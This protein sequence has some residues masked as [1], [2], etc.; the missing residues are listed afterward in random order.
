MDKLDFLLLKFGEHLKVIQFAERSIPTYIKNVEYFI[1]YLRSLEITNINEADRQV[2]RDYQTYTYLQ[3]YKGKPLSPVTQGIRLTAVHAFYRYLLQTGQVL[4][5]PSID[6]QMPKCPEQLPKGILS[7]KEI[8]ELLSAPNLE[9]PLGIRDRAILE[10][11][12][13]TGIRCTELINLTLQ[14]ID[15]NSGEIRINQG[16]N[17]KDRLAPLGEVARD[18]LEA[19][20]HQSRPKLAGSGENLLFVTYRGK[21]LLR[22]DLSDLVRKYTQKAGLKKGV[23]PHGLRHTCATHLLKGK[24][25]I[26]QIQA[27]LGH[28]SIATTQRYTRVEITD[29]KRV[30]KR[31]HPRERKEIEAGEF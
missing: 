2:I 8:G 25:D 4:Y 31:C 27:I 22:S 6:L 18:F 15:L 17:A 9:T 11:F 26:R 5:D 20:L 10:V 19:Y 28:K 24:A 30:L 3:T 1:D 7:K 29:L 13:S 16:K 14:D 21:R 12:Y 23:S